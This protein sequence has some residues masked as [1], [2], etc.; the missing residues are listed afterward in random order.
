MKLKNKYLS[1]AVAALMT[2]LI[3]SG[4]AN[5]KEKKS[6]EEKISIETEGN[7]LGSSQGNEEEN[8]TVWTRREK[9]IAEMADGEIALNDEDFMGKMDELFTNFHKYIGREVSYEGFVYKLEDVEE[10]IFVVG[11]YYDISHGAHSHET[12]IGFEGLYDGVWPEVNTWVQVKG[13]IEERVLDGEVLPALRI[14]Q[15]T[16]KAERGQ[17]KVYD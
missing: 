7:S 8:D 16:E 12:V 5:G 14:N 11:R 15:I 13:I 2:V 9:Y 4:C 17:E 1:C 3:L 6:Q 10:D